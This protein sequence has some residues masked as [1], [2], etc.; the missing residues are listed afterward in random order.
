MCSNNNRIESFGRMVLITA[1]GPLAHVSAV[2]F[3]YG[4]VKKCLIN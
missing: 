1:R 3:I 4:K 2:R